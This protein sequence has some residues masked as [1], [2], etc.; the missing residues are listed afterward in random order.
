VAQS[1]VEKLEHYNDSHHLEKVYIGHDKPFYLLGDTIWCQAIFVDGRTHQF[2]NA[3]PVLHVD[4]IDD[5]DE[6][7]HNYI[8]KID[9]GAAAFEIPTSYDYKPGQYTLRAYTQFQRNFDQ[10]YL[11]QKNI[12][13]FSDSLDTETKTNATAINFKTNFFPEGGEIISGLNNKV[14]VKGIYWSTL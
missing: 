6:L 12:R 1:V 14:A 3:S 13:I 2:F 9:Q 11:F 7:V 5:K 4:W 10:A 8:L